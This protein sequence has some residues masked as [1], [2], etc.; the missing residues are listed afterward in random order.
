MPRTRYLIAAPVTA[1]VLMTALVTWWQMPAEEQQHVAALTAANQS[2][3]NSGT[4]ASAIIAASKTSNG[5]QQFI[6]GLENLPASLQD[7]DVDGGFQLDADGNLIITNRIRQLFDYFLSAQ[8]EESLPTIVQRLRAYIHNTLSGDAAA[9]AEQLLESYLGYLDDVAALDAPATPVNGIDPTQLRAQKEQLEA[10]RAGRFDAVAN[11]AF[12]A[13]EEAYDHYTL[14]RLEVMQNED[15][16]A[17][18]RASQLA[19]LENQLPAE[20]QESI[21]DITR[22]Q[23]LQT[24]TQQWQETDGNP[25]NLQQMRE[26]LVGREAAERLAKLDQERAQWQQRV[27]SWLREREAILANTGISE[28]DKERQIDAVRSKL[29]NEQEQIRVKSLEQASF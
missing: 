17:E 26:N 18:E 4:I 2:K 10:I 22:Y 25:A 28:A 14:S 20:L 6:T 8:G 15:L 7:T 21:R 16:S 1:F 13:E 24:L 11:D 23:D 9:E 29:F 12:F 5:N 3:E 19:A 27:D